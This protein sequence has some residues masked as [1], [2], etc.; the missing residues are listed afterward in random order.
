MCSFGHRFVLTCQY[1]PIEQKALPA[2]DPDNFMGRLRKEAEP[3]MIHGIVVAL[4]GVILL[5]LG[6][7]AWVL[8]YLFP[9]QEYYYSWAEK[10]DIWF[11]LALLC[12]FGFYTV[13][14]IG[15]RLFWGL[16]Q[17]IKTSKSEAGS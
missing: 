13:I 12:M 7:F 17:E 6:G 8:S 9:A 5:V 11:V 2:L 15:I 16:R 1:V 14:R 3:L 4:L 10:I